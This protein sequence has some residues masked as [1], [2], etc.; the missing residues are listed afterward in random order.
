MT[1]TRWT[2]AM[3][4]E[5]TQGTWQGELPESC[6]FIEI[7]TD[8]RAVSPESFFVPLKGERFDAHDFISSVVSRG[9]RAVMANR[10]YTGTCSVPLLRVDDTLKAYQALARYHREKMQQLTVIGITGSSGKTSTKDMLRA[11]L[12]ALVGSEKVLAT[13]GNLNNHI[14]VPKNLLNLTSD[15]K[16]AVIE[17]GTNHHGEI[18]VLASMAQPNAALIT[19]IG[20]SHL[21]YFGTQDEVAREKAHV[22][23]NMRLPQICV[24]PENSDGQNFIDLACEGKECY[25]FGLSDHA[26]MQVIWK[27]SSLSHSEFTLKTHQNSADVAWSVPGRHQALNAAAVALILTH[28]GFSLSDVANA[29]SQ[30]VLTGMRSL[31]TEREG[32]Q[33]VNDAYNANPESMHAAIAWLSEFANPAT[34]LLVLGDMR[35]LG[36]TSKKAHQDV[37]QNVYQSLPGAKL[38]LVGPEFGVA[39][40]ALSLESIEWFEKSPDAADRV[41]SLAPLYEIVFLKASRG[42]QIEAV[43]PGVNQHVGH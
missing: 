22:F 37:I 4:A 38:I 41:Q 14:G 27:G 20:A 2:P 1:H 34:L 26:D 28:L 18:E 31:I 11:A 10:S 9:A 12:C 7:I 35:E 13:E 21:E 30:T 40:E 33:W 17:M 29:L 23:Q 25:M 8:S 42:T 39:R 24:I 6:T 16:Y 36:A 19:C 3:L 32:V 43:E 5:A 15:H